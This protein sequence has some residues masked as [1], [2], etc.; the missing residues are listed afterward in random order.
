MNFL[1]KGESSVFIE[2]ELTEGTYVAPT[3]S[4]SAIEV[5]EDFSGFSYTRDVIERNVLSSTIEAEKPRN[6]LPNVEGSIPTELKAGQIEGVEPR[7][8]KLFESL[9]GGVAVST[10]IISTTGH[11][12][13]MINL[14]DLSDPPVVGQVVV[15]KVAGDYFTTPV[16]DRSITP[17]AKSI[18]VFPYTMPFPDGVVISA[19]STYYYENNEAPLSVTSYLGGEVAEKVAGAKVSSAELSW[20]TGA[21]PKAAFSLS[22]LTYLKEIEVPSFVPDFSLEPQPAVALDACVYINGV[23][24]DYNSFSLSINKTLS[25]LLSACK[26]QGKVSNRATNLVVTGSINPYMSE[27]NVTFFNSFNLGSPLNL[28]ITL[29]NPSN[30]PG[31]YSNVVAIWMPQ[32]VLTAVNNGDQDGILTDELEFQSYK[33]NGNDTVFISFI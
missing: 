30:I 16:L 15:I 31:Q 24:F 12:S 28:L 5:E 13:S 32:L 20:E 33:K 1:V 3:A 10:E 8:G 18:T 25:T 23:E 4:L 14:S 9:L 7:S 2:K 19:S 11:T 26:P 17:G 22:A 29:K 27:T 21:I 6:G